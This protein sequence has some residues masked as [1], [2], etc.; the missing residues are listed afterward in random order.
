[1]TRR[2]QN[3]A[4]GTLAEAIRRL[5]SRRIEERRAAAMDLLLELESLDEDQSA[6]AAVVAAL[7]QAW[8]TATRKFAPTRPAACGNSATKRKGP[9]VPWRRRSAI[10]ATRWPR[11]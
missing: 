2:K 8:A 1:M 6:G 3:A 11:W 5:Q 9:S 4:E 7:A 10:P